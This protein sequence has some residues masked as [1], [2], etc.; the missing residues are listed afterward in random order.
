METVKANAAVLCNYEVLT[1]LED[2]RKQPKIGNRKNQLATVA[3]ETTKYLKGT[4]CCNQTPESIQN[5]LKA[6]APFGLTK[7]EKLM[8]VNLR[9][10]TPVE[11]QLVIEESEERMTD[12]Q[13]EQLLEVIG[14]HLPL[15]P[16]APVKEE[17]QNELEEEPDL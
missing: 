10:S 11:I 14:Q 3:Y 8:L 4:P 13:V 7:A 12:A 17:A 9:P 15:D 16:N 2:L 6:V 1:L 5:F